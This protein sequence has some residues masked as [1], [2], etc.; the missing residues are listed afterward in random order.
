MKNI[1][2]FFVLSLVLVGIMGFKAF[3]E[4]GT[5]P[6]PVNPIEQAPALVDP[7]EKEVPVILT[8]IIIKSPEAKSFIKG[9]I[10]LIAD[11]SKITSLVGGTTDGTGT[12]PALDIGTTPKV[13]FYQA[14]VGTNTRRM[15]KEV[16]I[17]N[18]K[19]ESGICSIVWDTALKSDTGQIVDGPYKIWAKTSDGINNSEQVDVMVD[20]TAPLIKI[21]EY[22]TNPTNQDIT[23]TATAN[24]GK[25]NVISY[26][27]TA[28]GT[29]DF[30]ATDEAGNVTTET[31]KI[32]NIDKI[33]P[34]ITIA[35]YITTPT[36]QD[37]TVTATTN[38]GTLNVASH[39]FTANGSFDFVA[40]DTAGNVTTQT[41]TISNIDKT[42]PPAVVVSR[43]GG[44]GGA[45][46]VTLP[47]ITV[48]TVTPSQVVGKVLGATNFKFSNYLRKGM[49]H[50]DV[51]ELQERLRTEG[52]FNITPSIKYFGVGTLKAVKAYQKAHNIPSTGFVGPLTV[53]EL[54]K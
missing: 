15:V 17:G 37:I 44:G 35:P 23:V 7:I 42:P 36:N 39:I 3:A 41:V 13:E 8:N 25:L 48:P 51:K 2:Y 21:A 38:E 4:T 29:F 9:K 34:V 52:L 27:F 32:T 1:K 12:T 49:K 19:C 22:I 46:L 5:A 18:G 40:T 53:A 11:I 20:N 54:N 30:T 26:T 33:A 6:D 24:E 43:G 10:E 31:V 45:F 28:N 47:K 50:D 14:Y 16:L